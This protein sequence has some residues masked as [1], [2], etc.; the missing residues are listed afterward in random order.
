MSEIVVLNGITYIIPDVGDEDWGQNVTDYLVAIP[1]AVLQRS[2]GL[3]PL[4]ADANFGPT[5]GLI[6][7]YFKSTSSNLATAGVLRLANADN[8]EWRNFANSGNNVLGVNSSDQLTYNGSPL[9][10]GALPSGDIFVGNASNVATAVTM[11][12]D[13]G[14]T[15]AG[16][17]SIQAGVIINADINAAAAIAYSKLN[18][19]GMIVNNDIGSSAS[20]AYSKLN[21]ANSV[22]LASD[23]TGNL[24]VTHL[25]SGTGAS[26][27]S[28]WR[29]DGTWATAGGAGVSSIAGTA[30]EVIASAS[31][32][33]VTLSLPQ[34]IDTVSSPSFASETLSN[35]SNQLTFGNSGSLTI[36]NAT[37][38]SGGPG[39]IALVQHVNGSTSAAISGT[40]AGNFLSLM[41]NSATTVTSVTDGVN[42]WVRASLGTSSSVNATLWYAENIVGTSGVLTVV[43]HGASGSVLTVCEWSG[44]RTSGSLVSSA[45]LNSQPSGPILGP[46]LTGSS[47][48]L[49]AVAGDSANPSSA[50]APW[51]AVVSSGVAVGAYYIPSSTVTSGAVFNASSTFGSAGA[52]FLSPAAATRT[53]TVPDE[54]SDA[55]FILAPNA[56]TSGQLLASNGPGVAPTFQTITTGSGTVNS[57]TATHL[58]YYATSTTAVSDANGHTIS[59]TY[60]FSGGA[61]AITLSSSTIAMGTNKITGLATPTASGDALSYG[62]VINGSTLTLSSTVDSNITFDNTSTHGVV[63]TTTNDSAASGNVG[64]YVSSDMSAVSYPTSTQ[65]GDLTSISLTAGDWDVHLHGEFENNSA[66]T[67]FADVGLSTTSGNSSTGLTLGITYLELGT[68]VVPTGANV[69]PF[70]GLLIRFSLSGSST[71]Y[72]K[73]RASYSAGPPLYMGRVSARRI[74]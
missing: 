72:V 13:I 29:G 21:L 60:T 61:G 42:T 31:T 18:L 32:G 45:N 53:Y 9:E 69:E 7:P 59:G 26:S 50:S 20:I 64:E 57:G 40:A 25:N 38:P 68:T 24:A 11:T 70:G 58:S 17:T 56:G 35:S 54:S 65:W 33:A 67:S 1:T 36:I 16:V 39:S 22:N 6:S 48:L 37:P 71:I 10:L 43:A 15:N 63:G 3:F 47:L 2:G 12:G 52:V 4:S 66:T 30:H 27:T 14:I 74:R 8:I 62:N 41:V 5:F 46:T 23:V 55:M 28:F 49:C 34:A 73:A 19:T 51:T 44:V